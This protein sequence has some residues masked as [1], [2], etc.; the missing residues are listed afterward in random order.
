MQSR[1]FEAVLFDLGSTLIYF[2]AVWA[3]IN[4]KS[5][6]ELFRALREAGL[7]LDEDVFLNTF[8][9]EMES[10]YKERETEFIEYTTLFILRG[11]LAR[12]GHPEVTEEV[13]RSALKAMYAVPQA[14]WKAEEDTLDTLECLRQRG[15]RLAIIS[16]AGDDA[17]VQVL[18]D[19]AGI[20]DYFE[21]IVTSASLGIRKPNPRIFQI[22]L[23]RLG[24]SPE[25]AV[26]VGDTLGADILGAQNA[27]LVGI[28][29]DRRGD[30]PGNRAHADTIHPDAVIHSLREL[31]D[32]LENFPGQ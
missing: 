26:M 18:V 27:G 31:P 30:V 28:W 29:I 25:K 22:V 2:D 15:Y 16:N 23:E 7:S 11:L 1:R 21:V 12:Y 3:E 32:L 13:L 19:Q 8:R 17:D 20:R 6:S 10:Y 24:V 5:S 4:R 9:R 14:F